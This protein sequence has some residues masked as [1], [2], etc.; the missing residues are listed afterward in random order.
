MK[1]PNIYIHHHPLPYIVIDNF[2]ENFKEISSQAKAL[3]PEAF[4]GSHNGVD[5][6]GLNRKELY[7]FQKPDITAGLVKLAMDEFW[8]PQYRKTWDALPQPFSLMNNTTFSDILLGF[9]GDLD[10]YSF[11]HDIGFLTSIIYLHEEKNFMGGE[12]ILTNK[13]QHHP[14]IEKEEQVIVDC[15][16]NRL[17]LFPSCYIHGVNGILVPKK[18]HDDVNYMRIALSY[19]MSFKIHP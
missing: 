14:F 19:F 10:Q 11:H 15:V 5:Y 3:Y 16:P 18:N 1:R 17:V 6:P 9:Y 2:F 12:F 13:K 7:L 4:P 8:K